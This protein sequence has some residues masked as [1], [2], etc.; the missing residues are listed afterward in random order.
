M[1]SE[2]YRIKYKPIQAG[3]FKVTEHSLFHS[4][5]L[6]LKPALYNR[7]FISSGNALCLCYLI[8]GHQPQ[9]ATT[10]LNGQKCNWGTKFLIFINSSKSKPN[11]PHMANGCHM[12][13]E[14]GKLKA[15]FYYTK[16]T[17]STYFTKSLPWNTTLPQKGRHSTW[18]LTTAFIWNATAQW[19]IGRNRRKPLCKPKTPAPNIE[20][21]LRARGSLEVI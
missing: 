14:W 11:Y 12:Y 1:S 4:H 19:Q 18:S 21:F 15:N 5:K 16:K 7:P 8:G 2:N 10:H 13:S 3:Y 17:P 9:V 20:L 6:H